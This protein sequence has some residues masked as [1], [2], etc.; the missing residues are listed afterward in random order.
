M[1]SFVLFGSIIL[2]HSA[3]GAE[4]I[5]PDDDGSQRAYG[6]NVGW[7]NFEPNQGGGVTVSDTKLVG[8]VWAENIGWINL[9]PANFGGVI[10]D[11]DGNLSG[12]AWGE[13]VGWVNF[14]PTGSRVTIDYKGNFGGYAWGENIGWIHFSGTAKDSTSYKVK[15]AWLSTPPGGD[16]PRSSGGGG[17]GCFISIFRAPF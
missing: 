2:T 11:G 10:N 15:T 3:G 5:D 12:Y 6:E 16:P 9:N 17:G 1:M 4:N 7:V 8:Y 13:N 14:N